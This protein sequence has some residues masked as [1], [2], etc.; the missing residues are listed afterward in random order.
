MDTTVISTT[1][2]E[3]FQMQNG[4]TEIP[5]LPSNHSRSRWTE[6]VAHLAQFGEMG[7]P[8]TVE[9]L[10]ILLQNEGSPQRRA[11][12][13]TGIGRCLINEGR[14]MDGI[15]ALSSAWQLIENSGGDAQAFVLL[16]MSSFM[17]VTAQFDLAL[18]L[19]DR[20]P[21]LT[22]SEYLRRLANYYWLVIRSRRKDLGLLDELH[23]SMAYFTGIKEYGTVAYHL[24]NLGNVHRKLQNLSA[25][26]SAYTRSLE[27]A[28][29]HGYE[30]IRS[31]VRHDLGLL[32]YHQKKTADALEILYGNYASTANE[33]TRCL[34]LGNMGFILKA[35]DQPEEAS[36]WLQRSLDI[37]VRENFYNIIPSIAV[38]LAKVSES[39]GSLH[40]AHYYYQA[41]YQTALKLLD[42]HYPFSGDRKQAVTGYTEFVRQH[43]DMDDPDEQSHSLSFTVNKTLRE[44]RTVFQNAV[45]DILMAETGSTAET[46]RRLSIS[47]RTY[48]AI[49]Q[50]NR[51]SR[52]APPPAFVGTFVQDHA[53]K[54][55]KELNSRFEA[56]VFPFLYQ[57]YKSNKKL[58][59]TKLAVSYPYMV[60][61]TN[62][63]DRQ[64]S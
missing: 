16:E 57:Q 33:Y 58:M 51:K 11:V 4:T 25:A 50:N 9:Q 20:I 15:A 63:L 62:N 13:Y 29:E 38:N 36:V 41:A 6:F 3:I 28:D 47:R 61:L 2:P 22:E 18:M 26:E 43:P 1:L 55:W 34:S 24:K 42:Q 54:N 23:S 14:F 21:R 39:T 60:A 56:A 5:R 30:H 7:I 27:L 35:D 48:Y 12:L 64:E 10:E 52:T 32:R 46:I 53:G 17:A 31:S 45:L 37:A 49:R 40:L 44:I 8:D 59:S 19:L